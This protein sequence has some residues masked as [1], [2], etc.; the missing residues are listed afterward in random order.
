[1]SQAMTTKS[2]GIDDDASSGGIAGGPAPAS[3]AAVSRRLLLKAA[4]AGTLVA[5]GGAAS[6]GRGRRAGGHAA[7]SALWEI[8][9]KRGLVFGSSTA[10]WQLFDGTAGRPHAQ[11]LRPPVRPAGGDRLHRG[12]PALVQAQAHPGRRAGLHATPTSCST[13]PDGTGSSS[14]PPTWSGTRA[15]ARAGPRTTCGSWTSRTPRSCCS[16]P[17]GPW[18]AATAAGRPAGSWPTRS[19]RPSATTPTSSASA[20]TCRGTRPSAGSTSRR[21]F[22]LARRHDPHATLVLNEFGF[23]T[24]NEFGDDPVARQEAIL[25]VI[26]TLQRQNVPLDAVGIQAHLL[27]AYWD[28]FNPRQYRRFLQADRRPRPEDP[29][30]RDGR[31]GRRP[32]RR[33]RP[34]GPRGR[35]DLRRLP[36]HHPGQPGGQV[37]DHL[38]AV[39]PVHLA[40]GGLPAGGRRRPA[41]AALRRGPAAASRRYRALRRELRAAP[42]RRP[43]WRSRRR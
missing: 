30:H 4:A 17:R 22:R 33:D 34:A 38:R 42:R 23:E 18:S 7:R 28:S 9:R 2:I 13:S 40:A 21:M 26:D 5:A 14:W 37:A 11:R 15:S 3:G 41:S 8:A 10:T 24:T 36:R 35:G 43:L 1:M 27:A 20:P 25:S 31:A 39:R 6:A 19:P 29:D 32:A 16:A 12:R